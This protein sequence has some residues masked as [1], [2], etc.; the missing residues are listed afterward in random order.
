MVILTGCNSGGGS[1][2]SIDVPKSL[3]GK[4]QNK[5]EPQEGIEFLKDGTVILKEKNGQTA[6]TYSKIDDKRIKLTNPLGSFVTSYEIKGDELAIYED[7]K[8]VKDKDKF[9]RVK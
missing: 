2:P 7:G 9:T 5:V 6:G 8:P 4:W 1:A 3:L